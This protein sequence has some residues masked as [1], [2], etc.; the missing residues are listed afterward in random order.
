M[1]LVSDKCLVMINLIT[2]W[3][4]GGVE[5]KFP[6]YQFLSTGFLALQSIFLAK[7]CALEWHTV[8]KFV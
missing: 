4:N 5:Q 1:Y 2:A 8:R 3:V 6:L 7:P